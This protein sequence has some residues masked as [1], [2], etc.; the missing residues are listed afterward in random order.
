M[1][2]D[3]AGISE[4]EGTYN[5]NERKTTPPHIIRIGKKEKGTEKL[6]LFF[7][8]LSISYATHVMWVCVY[9]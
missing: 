2:C 4:K 7:L 9:V 5:A 1:K 3:K 8:P 6:L